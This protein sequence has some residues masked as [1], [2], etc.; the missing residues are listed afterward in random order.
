V[1]ETVRVKFFFSSEEN[2]GGNIAQPVEKPRKATFYHVFE[3]NES[4]LVFFGDSRFPSLLVV[5]E[6]F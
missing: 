6:L 1:V 2:K 5:L 4:I 3:K